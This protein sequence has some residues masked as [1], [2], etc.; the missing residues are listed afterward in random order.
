[1]WCRDDKGPFVTFGFM[2]VDYAES[3]W[4]GMEFVWLTTGVQFL[5]GLFELDAANN[6]N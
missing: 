1:M 5:V 4:V 6:V 3:N 2:S